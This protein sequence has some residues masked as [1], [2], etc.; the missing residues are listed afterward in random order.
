[1]AVNLKE[2]FDMLV[3]KAFPLTSNNGQRSRPAARENRN[4]ES[5]Q[6]SADTADERVNYAEVKEVST[7]SSAEFI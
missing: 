7:N 2:K 3:E 4:D 6:E 5:S 1:M